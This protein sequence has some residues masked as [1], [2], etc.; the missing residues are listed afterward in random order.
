MSMTSLASAQFMAKDV[1]ER[2]ESKDQTIKLISQTHIMGIESGLSWANGYNQ[3]NGIPHLYCQ[4]ENLGLAAD[5]TVGI[6]RQSI[7]NHPEYAELPIGFALLLALQEV[8][9]CQ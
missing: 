3:A 2:Y 7:K 5:Q 1:L 8:F 6:L 4:P 9:P